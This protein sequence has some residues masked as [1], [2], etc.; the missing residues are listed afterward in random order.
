M[1]S[2]LTVHGMVQFAI[3]R[4]GN[5]AQKKHWLPRLATGEVIGAFGLTEPNVGS[6]AAEHRNE[7]HRSIGIPMS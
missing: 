6:D 3:L 1:R 2:L 7:C 5:E 4:W